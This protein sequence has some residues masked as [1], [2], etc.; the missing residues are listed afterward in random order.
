MIKL[1][2]IICGIKPLLLVFEVFYLSA[3]VSGMESSAMSPFTDGRIPEMDSSQNEIYDSV[4][5]ITGENIITLAPYVVRPWFSLDQKFTQEFANNPNRFKTGKALRDELKLQSTVDKILN[6]FFI[7][8]FGLQQEHIARM[9][10]KDKQLAKIIVLQ[11]NAFHN[12]V[13]TREM[14]QEKFELM[15]SKRNA[16]DLG[17]G[18]RE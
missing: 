9:F 5:P 15:K 7:R 1:M 8:V 17:L 18:G 14:M 10:A 13:M 4:D 2:K 12:K 16:I 3:T 11:N 6:P